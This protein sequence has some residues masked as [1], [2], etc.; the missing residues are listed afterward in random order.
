MDA[1][2]WAVLG[3][4]VAV[5]ILLLLKGAIDGA[6]DTGVALSCCTAICLLLVLVMRSLGTVWVIVFVLLL[7]LACGGFP[8]YFSTRDQRALQEMD[9]EDRLKY[10]AL[11]ERDPRNAS[12]HARL[13]ECYLK[14]GEASAAVQHLQAAVAIGGA[15][16]L[17]TREGAPER[18][19]LDTNPQLEKWRRRLRVAQE[20]VEAQ[21]NARS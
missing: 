10:I 6:I 16:T 12:A 8:Y 1:L 15:T 18:H 13:A 2:I 17:N 21:A 14:R 19:N 3:L 20:E 5:P 11:L 7:L 9:D 4:L